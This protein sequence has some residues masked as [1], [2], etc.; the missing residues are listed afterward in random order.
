M[1]LRELLGKI[2]YTLIQGSLDT[3]VTAVENDSRKVVENALFF[4]IS[5]AVFDGHRY[6]N[7]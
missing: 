6:A 5:G 4:C 1:K 2:E 7:F 3:E